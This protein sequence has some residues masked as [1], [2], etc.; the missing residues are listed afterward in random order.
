M[1]QAHPA[2]RQIGFCDA[3]IVALDGVQAAAARVLDGR[4]D[5]IHLSSGI[6]F[7]IKEAVEVGP[8]FAG[9]AA[10]LDGLAA[11]R[12]LVEDGDIEV[13]V[14]Q[15][16]QR[17]GD[18]GGTHDQQVGIR[19]L[20]GQQAPLAHTEAVLFVHDGQ[21]QPGELHALAEDGVGAYDEVGLVVPDGGEGGAACGGLHA[22]GE[23]GYPHPEGGE[24]AVQVLGV[25]AGQ[26]LGG[27]QQCGLIP[28]PDAGPDGRSGHQRFAAAH[29]ALQKAVH[30]RFA[31]HVGQD[32]FHGPPL[33]AGGGEGQ[34]LPERRGVGFLH[35]CAGGGRAVVLHPPDAQL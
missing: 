13:A 28:G 6:D 34:R 16:P 12:Q 31:R 19:G 33:C 17:P 10:G 20:F 22:A 18:G 27:G 11:R 32:L 29:V 9:D 4:A 24:Q 8:L 26:D 2:V 1:H 7:S 5:D 25:L 30:G 15:Q 23:Q 14:H 3:L 35:R 21:T